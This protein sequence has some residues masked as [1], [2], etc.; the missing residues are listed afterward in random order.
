MRNRVHNDVETFIF[1][2]NESHNYARWYSEDV[3]LKAKIETVKANC[4]TIFLAESLNYP[5]SIGLCF[6]IIILPRLS[7][8]LMLQKFL[9]MIFKMRLSHY[10]KLIIYLSRNSLKE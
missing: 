4:Q 9:M 10:E 2:L 3:R 5:K 6:E 7:L 8:H 1:Y